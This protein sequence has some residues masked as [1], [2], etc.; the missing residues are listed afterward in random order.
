MFR[1]LAGP[2]VAALAFFGVLAS[3]RTITAVFPDVTDATAPSLRAPKSQ[4][5]MRPPTS[6]DCDH[7]FGRL[8]RSDGPRSFD[9]QCHRRSSRIQES[10][11][12]GYDLPDVLR[13][14]AD[15]Q[16][17]CRRLSPIALRVP[18]VLGESIDTTV[19]RRAFAPGDS[20]LVRD[21][22]LKGRNYLQLVVAGCRGCRGC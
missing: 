18:E 5:R 1:L 10:E 9:V 13:L 12:K 11:K 16:D 14:P 4:S 2:G 20:K 17:R 19:R 6:A 7:Q 15:F 21:P 22:A 8:L 3:P